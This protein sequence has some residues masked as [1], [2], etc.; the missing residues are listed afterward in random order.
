MEYN[1]AA[2][3]KKIVEASKHT[4][5]GGFTVNELWKWVVFDSENLYLNNSLT[6]HN[7]SGIAVKGRETKIDTTICIYGKY[8]LFDFIDHA[9]SYRIISLKTLQELVSLVLSN[10]GIFNGFT[11]IQIP[12]INGEVSNLDEVMA[13]MDQAGL[14]GVSIHQEFINDFQKILNTTINGYEFYSTL[15]EA[16]NCVISF[17]EKGISQQKAYDIV[18]AIKLVYIAFGIH[19]VDDLIDEVL[20]HIS[21]YIGN[22]ELWIWEKPL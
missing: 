19:N 11:S 22:K 12:I 5:D 10:S 6:I 9:P 17:K 1:L 13:F 15:K 20:D 7:P 3:F 21:G 18:L 8:F 2:I 14:K 16:R 4:E